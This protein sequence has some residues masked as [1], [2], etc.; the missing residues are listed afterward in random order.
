MPINK[1]LVVIL[2]QKPLFQF[3]S[4][5]TDGCFAFNSLKDF[6]KS[7]LLPVHIKNI[8][9]INLRYV[10]ENVLINGYM[11]FLS[12]FRIFRILTCL[13]VC[14][15]VCLPASAPTCVPSYLPVC[16]SGCILSQQQLIIFV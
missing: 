10:R 16:L 12:N 7:V 6:S 15:H 2:L 8:S 3:S 14:L 1:F 4:N 5:L 11:N 9:S 13:L